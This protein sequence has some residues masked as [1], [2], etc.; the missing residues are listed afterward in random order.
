MGGRFTVKE[1]RKIVR[2]RV[3]KFLAYAL[4][5]FGDPDPAKGSSWEKGARLAG[6]I[7]A[8]RTLLIFYGLEPLQYPPGVMQGR[9]KDQGSECLLKELARG[10]PGL[11]IVTTRLPV[12]DLEHAVKSS[13]KQIDLEELSPV[14]GAQ[15]LN[16]VLS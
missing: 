3:M 16:L 11:C 15:L 1:L 10:N 9:L 7:R 12:V 2:H 13:V 4:G 8:Q 14:V 5:W 6:L